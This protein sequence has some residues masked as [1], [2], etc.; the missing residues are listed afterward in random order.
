MTVFQQALLSGE[1]PPSTR[2]QDYGRGLLLHEPNQPCIHN[3]QQSP[4]IKLHQH[5]RDPVVRSTR[6]LVP[7]CSVGLPVRNGGRFALPLLSPDSVLAPYYQMP[8]DASG[9]ANAPAHQPSQ[10][11]QGDGELSSPP[12]NC[13]MGDGDVLF[14]ASTLAAS[15]NRGLRSLHE[16]SSVGVLTSNLCPLAPLSPCH[17]LSDS[18]FLRHSF[19]LP[20]LLSHAQSCQRRPIWSPAPRSRRHFSGYWRIPVTFSAAYVRSNAAT[21][22]RLPLLHVGP[23][24]SQPCQ[25]S[26]RPTPQGWPAPWLLPCSI[27]SLADTPSVFRVAASPW[28]PPTT[29]TSPPLST[30]CTEASRH[31]YWPARTAG[32]PR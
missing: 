25:A 31:E 29:A 28:A 20:P 32:G 15:Y 21:S 22:G 14:Q 12:E 30:S 3:P 8:S 26:P 11:W 10:V 2:P 9:K 5:V 13:W 7:R 4:L 1:N 23:D 27:Y 19:P 17:A 24:L 6:F 16:S 18:H